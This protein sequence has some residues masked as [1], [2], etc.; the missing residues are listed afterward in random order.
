MVCRSSVILRHDATRE[1]LRA[2]ED[3]AHAGSLS[4]EEGGDAHLLKGQVI[5][6]AY[7]PAGSKRQIAQPGCARGSFL[8]EAFRKKT[9]EVVRSSARH[10]GAIA[11]LPI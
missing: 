9:D 4:H 10:C 1:A 3:G 5:A 8:H 2:I 11:G 7:A 6:D